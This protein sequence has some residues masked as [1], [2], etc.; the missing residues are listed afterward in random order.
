MVEKDPQEFT[1]EVYKVLMI[2]GVT[3]EEKEKLYTYQLKGV[4]QVWFNQWME[5][6]WLIWVLVIGRSFKLLSL[7]VFSP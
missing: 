1:D 2:M 7:W 5:A 3:M 6:R 4:A